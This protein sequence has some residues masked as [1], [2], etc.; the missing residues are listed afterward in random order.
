[1]QYGAVAMGTPLGRQQRVLNTTKH[2]TA[3]VLKAHDV[4]KTCMSDYSLYN[5]DM[6]CLTYD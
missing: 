4:T 6:I 2:S 1:M 5:H 3:I